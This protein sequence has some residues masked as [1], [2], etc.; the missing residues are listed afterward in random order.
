MMLNTVIPRLQKRY[1]NFR[2]KNQRFLPLK[3]DFL[4]KN[5]EFSRL[6]YAFQKNKNPPN[7]Q[8]L[9]ITEKVAFNIPCEVSYVYILSGQKFIENTING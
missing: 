1:M 5:V 2:A 6:K 7:T 9:K 8:C 4:K 3:F